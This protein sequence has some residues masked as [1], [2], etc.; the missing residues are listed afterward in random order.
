MISTLER[1]Y[2]PVTGHM[3][4]NVNGVYIDSM[5]PWLFREYVA[6]VQQGPVLYPGAIRH[7]ISMGVNI[8]TETS[9]SD[10]NDIQHAA[11]PEGHRYRAREVLRSMAPHA[12]GSY[13]GDADSQERLTKFWADPN[14]GRLMEVRRKWDPDGVVAGYLDAGDG[15]GTSGLSNKHDW[16]N[17]LNYIRA[18]N[19]KDYAKQ[20]AFYSEHIELK[21]PD[22]RVPAL[23]GKSAIMEHYRPLHAAADETVVPLVVM[24]DRGRIFLFMETYFKY[25]TATAA[26]IG[27]FDL[28]PDDV[29]KVE[30]FA[31]YD[32]DD[33]N[34]M[35]C[36][37]CHLINVQ[38]LGR[39]DLM[40]QIRDSETRADADLRLYN[41]P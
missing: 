6:L 27:E 14:A 24:C 18:F 25:K 12:V 3:N 4:M 33:G 32:L 35:N 23:V 38:K 39:V 26:G 16:E 29:V 41:Y 28:L 37:T 5:N 19:A 2:D 36:I 8:C 7:N 34:K 31:L 15:S 21:V 40:E 30:C 17:F 9:L 13:L 1:F 20:H 22:N 11:N 10:Q